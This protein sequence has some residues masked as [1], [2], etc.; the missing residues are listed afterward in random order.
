MSYLFERDCFFAKQ[1]ANKKN[2]FSFAQVCSYTNGCPKSKNSIL[3]A[4]SL[5]KKSLL[6]SLSVSL[7][8][9]FESPAYLCFLQCS[10]HPYTQ[11]FLSLCKIIVKACCVIDYF[12]CCARSM[13]HMQCLA[14]P[15]GKAN[16]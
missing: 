6:V 9:T 4:K 16:V 14:V 11:M 12:S 2:K 13:Y 15:M 8:G 10:K 1:K 7:K 5:Y 3:F